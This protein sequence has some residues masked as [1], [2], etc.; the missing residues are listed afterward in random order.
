MHIIFLHV[1]EINSYDLKVVWQ[2]IYIYFIFYEDLY[3]CKY[4]NLF[5]K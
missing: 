1:T 2:Y 5:M 4:R 3:K